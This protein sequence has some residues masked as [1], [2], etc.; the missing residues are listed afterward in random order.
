MV[1]PTSEPPPCGV[2]V[3]TSDVWRNAAVMVPA[4]Q[5]AAQSVPG[6]QEK[7]KT[8]TGKHKQDFKKPSKLESTGMTGPG[9]NPDRLNNDE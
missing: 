7:S 6:L 5:A 9:N 8:K 2:T 1:Q 4:A 3:T